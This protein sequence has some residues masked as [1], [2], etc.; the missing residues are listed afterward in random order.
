MSKAYARLFEC[1]RLKSVTISFY[2]K[3]NIMHPGREPDQKLFPDSRPQNMVRY[4]TALLAKLSCA[5]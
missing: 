4:Y 2:N 1:K 3:Y 5:E